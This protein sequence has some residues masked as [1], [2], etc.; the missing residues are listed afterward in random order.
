M[1]QSESPEFFEGDD[2]GR[3]VVV[4]SRAAMKIEIRRLD[5]HREEKGRVAL[6]GF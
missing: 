6:G 2:E 5:Q 3:L 4:G 1:R